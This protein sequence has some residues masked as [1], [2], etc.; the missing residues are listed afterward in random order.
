MIQRRSTIQEELKQRRPFQSP[1][2][3]AFVALLRTASVVRR[4]IGRVIEARGIS[5][6]QY[7]VLRILRGAGIEGLPTL[8]IR[9]RMIEEAAGI[10]RLIDKLEGA[11]LVF[12]DR[13]ISPDRRQVYCRITESGLALLQELDHPV[14]DVADFALSSLTDEQLATFCE[15]LDTLRG[16]HRHEREVAECEGGESMALHE[17]PGASA[18]ATGME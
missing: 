13:T 6:A 16:A 14:E 5:M 9:E 15:L 1:R 12:R 10:T 11:G 4:P 18:D 7:N 8:T 2:E 3:E 17:H